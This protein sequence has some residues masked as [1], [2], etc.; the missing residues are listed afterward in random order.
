MI[1]N[2]KIA[3]STIAG[4][5][6]TPLRKGLAIGATSIVAASGLLGATAASAT[7]STPPTPVAPHSVSSGHGH[8]GERSLLRALHADLF[9]ATIDGARAQA[10]ATRIV[11][12]EALFAKLPAALQTA[13]TTLKNAPAADAVADAQL[14]K[15]TAL[16]GGYGTQIEKLAKALENWSKLP[17]THK[18][19]GEL[20]W[21]TGAAHT[22]V[23]VPAGGWPGGAHKTGTHPTGTHATGTNPEGANVA[24]NIHVI[25]H[26]WNN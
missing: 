13:L 20:P 2:Q 17:S 14:I 4:I 18:L 22:F 21:G 5:L 24:T 6:G 3:S 23:T 8:F 26:G 19:I 16:D 25:S 9:S 10:L 11:N 12:D 7:A 15:T 1:N